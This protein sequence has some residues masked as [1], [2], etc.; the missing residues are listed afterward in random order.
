M[1]NFDRLGADW[2]R[3]D[4]P[5]RGL[6]KFNPA[7]VAWLKSELTRHFSASRPA[8]PEKPL[9][10]LTLL[11]IGCGGGL[12]AESL[13]ELGADVTAIDPAPRNIEIAKAHAEKSRLAIDYRCVSVEAVALLR[14]TKKST[15]CW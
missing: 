15:P 3:P 2:W 9:A 12:V 8:D 14:R 5:M 11:D 7:R 4:G 10:G 13:A 6:H 1:S